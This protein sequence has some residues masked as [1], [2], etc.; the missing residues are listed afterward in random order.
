[1]A[2]ASVCADGRR[3]PRRA[4]RRERRR[5]RKPTDRL[6]G[7]LAVACRRSDSASTH[8]A[9][10]RVAI[11][12]VEA[13]LARIVRFDPNHL[14]ATQALALRLFARGALAEAERHAR[15]AVRIAPLDAQSHN[16]MGMI[17]TEA[18]RPQ[19]G[20]HHYRR[21]RALLAEPSPIL[22]ANLAWNLKNQGRM[23]ESR[24]ALRSNP[25][26]STPKSSRPSSAG[27][28]WRRPTAISRARGELLDAAE[29]VCAGA[30]EREAAA[31]GAARPRQRPMTRRSRRLD[32]IEAAC[33]G[34][35][36]ADRR[37]REGHAARQDGPPCRGLRRVRRRQAQAARDSPA[38]PISPRRR[39]RWRERLKGF[40]VA[41]AAR[42]PAARGR[43]RRC[44]AADLH[45]RLSALRHDD[46]RA[47][48]D[49]ASADRRR[50]RTADRQ[51][52]D[53]I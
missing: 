26:R 28:R 6:S 45:R 21:A 20:E 27:R 17:M 22:L 10:R 38:S 32:E 53:A 7:E 12:R 11:L 29:R 40:F 9:T 51:R 2:G 4:R 30:P 33:D 23:A 16:L 43:A 31:R 48:A 39:R 37:E 36:R 44:R 3:R 13:L 8:C 47:D 50:R 42:H 5:S 46:D 19:V 1:M 25:S 14:A 15:N 24:G 18:Q 35:A 34:G 52:T 41:I 49:R